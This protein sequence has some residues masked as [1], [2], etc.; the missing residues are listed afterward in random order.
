MGPCFPNLPVS[1]YQA[2]GMYVA[3]AVGPFIHVCY[4]SSQIG[5][6]RQRGCKEFFFNAIVLLPLHPRRRHRTCNMLY[7]CV[8]PC[9][10]AGVVWSI[11]GRSDSS[12][13]SSAKEFSAFHICL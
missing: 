12:E 13:N 11:T 6:G 4:A 10:C 9:F 5:K 7:S 3:M 1:L 2:E 8:V